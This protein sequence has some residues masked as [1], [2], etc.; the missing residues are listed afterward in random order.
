MFYTGEG[1]RHLK[2]TGQIL[3]DI[4]SK[5]IGNKKQETYVKFNKIYDVVHHEMLYM[6][7]KYN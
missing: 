2:L 4:F 3:S 1:Y 5:D 7:E 6:V